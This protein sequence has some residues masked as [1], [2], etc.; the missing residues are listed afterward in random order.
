MQPAQ[1]ILANE[2]SQYFQQ[3]RWKELE[4]LYREA[5]KE[6]EADARSAF[7]L[8]NL[9]AYQGRYREALAC[10]ETAWLHKWP[11]PIALNNKGVAHSCLGEARPAFKALWDAAK[12]EEGCRPAA[13]NLGILCEKLGNE[14]S[15]PAVILDL[16]VGVQGKKASEIAQEFFKQALDGKGPPGVWAETGPLDRP[17]F[18]WV[19]DL[20]SGFGF[21][22]PERSSTWRALPSSSTKAGA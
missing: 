11:G 6:D 4:D 12:R 7:R 18:L 8:G 5:L 10:F 16:G 17:L 9:L 13:Y 19:E 20:R 15:L 22:L 1:G 21:E 3:G 2:V 14:G